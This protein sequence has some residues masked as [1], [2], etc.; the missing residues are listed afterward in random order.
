MAGLWDPDGEDVVEA[1]RQ[2]GAVRGDLDGGGREVAVEPDTS[3]HPDT[4]GPFTRNNTHD[5]GTLHKN[6]NITEVLLC[7]PWQVS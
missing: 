3:A 1:G 6:R 2:E 5:G 4:L 7:V